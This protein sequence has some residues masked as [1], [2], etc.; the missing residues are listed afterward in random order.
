MVG[1]RKACTQ[2]SFE[3]EFSYVNDALFFF[4]CFFVLT[5]AVIFKPID[6]YS[7]PDQ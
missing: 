4:V 5:R 7:V 1:E 2:M 6:K 3:V